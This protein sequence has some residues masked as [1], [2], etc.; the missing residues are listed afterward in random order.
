M[1]RLLDQQ[2]KKLKLSFVT[3]GLNVSTALSDAVNA[4]QNSDAQLAQTV[5]DGDE[6]INEQEVHLEGKS[7]QI[8]ALQQPVAGDLRKI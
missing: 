2:I 5:I 1:S 8:I 3:M 4:W 7:A 6:N